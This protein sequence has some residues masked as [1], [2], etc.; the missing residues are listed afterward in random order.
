MSTP[1]LKTKLYIPP[2]RPELVSRPRLIDQLNAGYHRKLTLISAPAGFGKTTLLVEWASWLLEIGDWESDEV[3]TGKSHRPN[4]QSPRVAWLSLD[5]ADNDPARFWTYFAAALQTTAST[6]GVDLQSAFQAPQPP[7]IESLLAA[8]INELAA[9]ADDLFLV[10]DDYHVIQSQPIHD[11]LG[12]LLDH[13]PPQVHLVIATR[14]DPPL[15]LARLRGRGQITELRLAE[16]R[17]TAGEIAVFLDRVVGQE[18]CADDV[19]TLA[20]R[21]EGWIAGL[22]MAALALSGQWLA[23]KGQQGPPSAEHRPSTTSQFIQTFSGSDRY[24][25]DYLM[26]EVLQRQPENI[27]TFLLQTSILERLS[28]PLCD[29]LTGREDGRATLESIERANLFV[30]PLDNERCWYRYHR[31][32]ADLL[33]Q[34]L[35]VAQPDLVATLHRRA[36]TWYERNGLMPEAIDHAF[37][38]GDYARAAEL[39]EEAA[40]ATWMRSEVTTFVSWVEALPQ[41]VMRQKSLLCVYHAVALFVTGH[42]LDAVESRLRDAVGD[43]STHGLSG[44]VEVIRGLIAVLQGQVRH[45]IELAHRALE[46]LPE[47]SLLLRSMVSWS[48]GVAYYVRGEFATAFQTLEEAARMGQ[49]A[50]NKMIAVLALCNVAEL[51]MI[52]GRL[53]DA[54]AIYERALELGT[55]ELGRRLPIAGLALIG[56]GELMR[57]GNDLPGAERHLTEGIDLISKWGDIVGLDGYVALARVKQAQGDADGANKEMRKVQQLALKFDIIEVDDLLVAAFQ[58][59]LWIAQGNLAAALRWVQ[60]RRLDT[61]AALAALEA[62]DSSDLFSYHIHE[63]ESSTLARLYIAQGR[64][65]AALRVLAPLL[66]VAEKMGR[67]GDVI[68]IL[69]LRALALH[70]QGELAP[71]LT[72]LERALSLAEPEGYVRLFL[73]A[74]EPMA[75]LLYQ[76][77]AHGIAPTY[78]GRLLAAFGTREDG[79]L[80]GTAARPA[81]QPLIEPLSERELEVLELIAEGLSN[82]EIAQ[83]LYISLRTVKW[84]SSNIYGKLGVK[85]RTQAVT[86]ARSLG[87]FSTV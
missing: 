6:V 15:H 27:Q 25:L 75:Q 14:S 8:M 67:V 86:K 78:T 72:D 47:D 12:F 18:L 10:L 70:A 19:A 29:A 22:Q 32:F 71:A 45:S 85:N 11:G 20:A 79:S 55:D 65:E 76:A 73:D 21:T 26:E 60:E 80:G 68:E 74:E 39:I 9:L 40:E 84:H 1:L 59:R 82:Q 44:E 7:A 81:A 24:V 37:G 5:D 58:A 2:M 28:G 64:P 46:L 4:I 30:V 51:R 3:G 42:P 35:Q 53:V 62:D 13:L 17:F 38:A 83:R 57:E 34:R 66:K 87:I 52:H 43:G 33:R 48:L 61:A 54:R 63:L 50:G 41:K 36:S 16:L 77:A 49:E 56:L 23:D 69:A 31:L